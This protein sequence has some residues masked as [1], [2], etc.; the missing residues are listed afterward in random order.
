MLQTDHGDKGRE[1]E[2]ETEGGRGGGGEL[3]RGESQRRK[4]Q[5]RI[6]GGEGEGK[7]ALTPYRSKSSSI[8]RKATRDDG[9]NKQQGGRSKWG[10]GHGARGDARVAQSAAQ[11]QAREAARSSALADLVSGGR[12]DGG[13]PPHRPH[14]PTGGD[15]APDACHSSPG[16]RRAGP[17]PQGTG[18]AAELRPARPEQSG[19]GLRQP[20]S[21]AAPSGLPS[22]CT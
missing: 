4:G 11:T 1:R 14:R 5:G 16:A 18:P 21:F 17:V 20:T 9:G 2:G 6:G 7:E 13:A 10:W 15:A 3:R 22:A 8:G 12:A 19:I